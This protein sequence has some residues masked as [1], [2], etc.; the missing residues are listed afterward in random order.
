MTEDLRVGRY[1]TPAPHTVGQEQT[2]AI[3]HKLMREHGVRHLP[4]L[5]SSAL[6]GMVTLR[7]LDLV[8]AFDSLSADELKVE[9]AM[10]S[11]LY[12]VAEETSLTEVV[13]TMVDRGISSTVIVDPN[14]HVLGVFSTVDALRALRD[15]L[16]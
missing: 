6:V 3:A 13:N 11:D 7:D 8:E 2:L 10:T 5:H 12:T 4:V 14:N 1:M 15:V 16:A 9:D